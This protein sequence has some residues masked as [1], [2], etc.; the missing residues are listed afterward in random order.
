MVRI[1]E[2]QH[3][4]PAAVSGIPSSFEKSLHSSVHVT[5]HSRSTVECW[6]MGLFLCKFHS[7]PLLSWSGHEHSEI[8]IEY[9]C[10]KTLTCI[11]SP[12]LENF[13]PG[14]IYSWLK[15]TGTPRCF[16]I[17]DLHKQTTQWALISCVHVTHHSVEC[18]EEPC[19]IAVCS[20]WRNVLG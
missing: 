13:R 4:L 11:L 9:R 2:I 20:H 1:W 5:C 17:W 14:Y 8:I 12:K 15:N 19:V 7:V 3:C 6:K 16:R 10:L 18:W